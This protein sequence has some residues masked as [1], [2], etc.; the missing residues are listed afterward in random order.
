MKHAE[1]L[2]G[3]LSRY[4]EAFLQVLHRYPLAKVEAMKI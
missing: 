4:V 3:I 2:H 1:N